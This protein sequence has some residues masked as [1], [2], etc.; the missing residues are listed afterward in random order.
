MPLRGE[1]GLVVRGV[2][3]P[4]SA[5]GLSFGGWGEGNF[6]YQKVVPL[7]FCVHFNMG[8]LGTGTKGI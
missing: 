3:L 8:Q 6:K 4:S 1:R 5:L 7:L 2:H